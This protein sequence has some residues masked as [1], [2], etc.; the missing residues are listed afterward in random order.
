MTFV[1]FLGERSGQP[2][3]LEDIKPPEMSLAFGTR[4]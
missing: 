4:H 1:P 3:T 2:R